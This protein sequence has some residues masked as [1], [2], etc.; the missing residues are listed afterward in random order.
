MFLI[1]EWG[2]LFQTVIP[3]P[4]LAPPTYFRKTAPHAPIPI[5]MTSFYSFILVTVVLSGFP[6]RTQHCHAWMKIVLRIST[7]RCY[8]A[9]IL[10]LRELGYSVVKSVE[11]LLEFGISEELLIIIMFL[12][13]IRGH[14]QLVLKAV[15][16]VNHWGPVPEIFPVKQRFKEFVVCPINHFPGNP[17]VIF[18]QYSLLFP[19]FFLKHFLQGRFI[20][21][22]WIHDFIYFHYLINLY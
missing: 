17:I 2:L 12:L 3:D 10:C 21:W 6:L 20:V 19:I 18:N 8:L 22:P 9:L 1:E 13:R 16:A 7:D 14:L 11:S 5:I 15:V 4:L